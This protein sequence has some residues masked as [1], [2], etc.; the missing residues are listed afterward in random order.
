MLLPRILTAILGIPVILLS[1]YYGGVVYLFLL[2]LI[3]LYIIR[4]FNYIVNKV[5]YEVSYLVSF[6]VSLII[7][8]SVIFEILKFNKTSIYLTSINLTLILILINLFELFRQKPIGAIGR[9]SVGFFYPFLFAWSLSHMY[10]LRD[11]KIYGMKL[12]YI[13]FFTIW[14][15]DN[16][17]YLFGTLFGKKKLASV[18][19]PKKTLLGFF[20]SIIFGILSFVFFARIFL[21]DSVIKFKEIIL[22]SIILAPLI[23]VSDLTESLI[24][25]DCGIKDTDNLLFGHGG[26]MDRFD[27]FLFTAPIYYYLVLFLI[28]K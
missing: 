13:L 4:E 26:M 1:V 21:I 27:S 8:F 25:R 24:K 3:L 28:E 14:T 23:T 20:S 12:T 9:L 11:I 17:A 18:I 16:A 5:G 22:I 7:F 15:A 6:L 2:L 19:S 10:L